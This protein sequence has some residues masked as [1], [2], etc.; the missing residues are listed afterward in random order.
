[1]E[2]PIDLDECKNFLEYWKTFSNYALENNYNNSDLM[3]S[4][5]KFL[6]YVN[7]NRIYKYHQHGADEYNNI[8]ESLIK[9]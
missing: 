6:N 7:K 4:F 8:W 3:K 5:E 2:E 9:S 1:L